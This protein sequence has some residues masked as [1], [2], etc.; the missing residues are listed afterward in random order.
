M[1]FKFF[2][3]RQ[4]DGTCPKSFTKPIQQSDKMTKKTSKMKTEQKRGQI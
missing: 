1:L 4:E 3:N 2:Q